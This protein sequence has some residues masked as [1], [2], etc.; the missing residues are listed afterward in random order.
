[1]IEVSLTNSAEP[2]PCDQHICGWGKE[3]VVDKKNRPVCECV[4]KCPILNTD[5]PL[6]QVANH[7]IYK[8]IDPTNELGMCQQQRDLF[9]V[10]R[11]LPV[12]LQHI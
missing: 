1:M 5:D 2:N 7:H 11:T 4:A 8:V 12:K 6:D 3:C 10:V 9:V